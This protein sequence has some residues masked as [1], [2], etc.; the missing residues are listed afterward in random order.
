V[1]FSLDP[2]AL[3]LLA[4]VLALYLRALAVVR[5]RGLTVPRG[6]QV[7]FYCG[8][9]LWAG[10]LLG[11]VDA[12]SEDLLSLHMAQHL[13]LA[14]LGA[15][16]ILFGIRAPVVF[17][18]LP[19]PALVALARRTRLRRVLAS[20]SRPIP[21][22]AIYAVVLYGWHFAL[23]FEAATENP[24]LH[25]LQHQS[26]IAISVLVWLPALE[27]TRRRMP[28]EL[29]KAGHIFGARLV[30]MFLGVAFIAMRT[31]AYPLYAER[32]PQHGLTGLEDQKIAGGMMMTLDVIIMLA[33]VAYFFWRS[34]Q[35]HDLA[36][37]K[38]RAR[39]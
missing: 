19:R 10:A 38:E 16:L 17:F 9:T 5:G 25:A 12:Y 22:I 39:G 29:W 24:L 13:L 7:A 15:P 6:Q 36:E 20:V 33:A 11:P 37:A 32:A 14:E 28:G 2:G 26:F 35:D 30:G 23:T 18:L 34:A 3:V 4:V 21:A 8:L 27:P 1:R 31:A